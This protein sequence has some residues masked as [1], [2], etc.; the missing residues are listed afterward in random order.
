MASRTIENERDR[1]MTIMTTT[2]IPCSAKLPIIAL[3]A[4]AL[5]GGAPWVAPSAYFVG[6]IAIIV[7]GIM[8]K[9]TKMFSGDPAPFVMELPA[10]HLPT[11]GSVLRS[12]WERAWSFIKKAGTIILLATV[13]VWFLQGF[14]F[15]DGGFGMVEDMD[16]SILAVIGNAIAWIFIPLGWGDWKSAV[17]AVTGLIAK[18]NVVGTFGILYGGFDEVAENG[19]QVWENMRA[20]FTQVSA[21]SFLIFNLLCAPCFAAIGAIRREMNSAKWT[22]F[23]I[24]YQCGFAYAVSLIVYQIGSA[25]CG[26][27]NVVGLVAAAVLLAFFAFMLFRPYKESNKLEK[28]VKIK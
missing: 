14:G 2:F 7:S 12:M 5:F 10:Y 18:E 4:G 9:K 8:L 16:N 21:Y 23:A 20:N 26:Q 22:W 25:L 6:V 3:I 19:W 28:N 11:V 13:L 27:I 15:E 24:A 17:A 1:R